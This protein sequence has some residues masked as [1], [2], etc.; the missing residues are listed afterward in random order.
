MERPFSHPPKRISD[1]SKRLCL[2]VPHVTVLKE[3]ATPN[4]CY[5]GRLG[6]SAALR[7]PVTNVGE[8]VTV[9]PTVQAVW[10]ATIGMDWNLF[11]DAVGREKVATT[12][13]FVLRRSKIA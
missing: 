3:K 4:P 2:G 8:T 11:Q 13:A 10:S 6:L 12:T 1:P 5:R 7:I 9:M